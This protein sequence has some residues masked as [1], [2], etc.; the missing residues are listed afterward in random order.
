MDKCQR[1]KNKDYETF[2]LS[3]DSFNFLCY[4]CDSYLHNKIPTYQSHKR[5]S[6]E[7][8]EKQKFNNE[9]N[10]VDNN[11]QINNQDIQPEQL[12]EQ[13]KNN[14]MASISYKNNNNDI[15]NI[16]GSTSNENSNSLRPSSILS[17]KFFTSNTY[18][19]EYLNEIKEVFRKEKNALEFKNK[20]LENTMERLKTSFTEQIRSL[21]KELEEVRQSNVIVV[22]GLKKEY[23]KK[24]ETMNNEHLEAMNEFKIVQENWG[25][26]DKEKEIEN[27]NDK[28]EKNEIINKLNEK[29][30]ELEQ[31]I[32]RK[33]EENLNLKYS[34]DC[35]MQ[36]NEKMLNE[37]KNKLMENYEIKMS[38]IVNNVENTKENLIKLVDQ[39]DIEIKTALEKSEEEI[40]RLN[41][42]ISKL[43][44]ENQCHKQNLI[45]MRD[46]REFFRRKVEQ[47]QENEN[48]LLCDN[49]CNV[50]QIQK[51][52]EENGYLRNENDQLKCELSKLDKLIYGKIRPNFKFNC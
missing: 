41:E 34:F 17:S 42:I 6:R 31:I 35:M 11:S 4:R 16:S 2:C 28:N 27:E 29:I 20:N 30:F 49:Q 5:I 47:C 14:K 32:K 3:C 12:E 46:E 22:E 8:Y 15:I 48:S 21:T 44:Q 24:I 13:S 25:K 45:K 7:D 37:Q 18:S 52:Q 51:L 36:Q 23:E 10:I 1:C 9:Q 33:D 43:T 50:T 19:K 38:E 39:R 40:K 26:R